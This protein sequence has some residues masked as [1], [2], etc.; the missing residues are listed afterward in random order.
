MKAASA[1]PLVGTEGPRTSPFHGTGAPPASDTL[2]ARLRPS[3]EHH[4]RVLAP[5][6]IEPDHRGEF[7][8]IEFDGCDRFQRGAAILCG[9]R[10]DRRADKAKPS[11]PRRAARQPRRRR[12]GARGRDVETGDPGMGDPRAQD[13]AFELPI[14]ADVRWCSAPA[15]HF[16]AC[17]QTARHKPRRRRDRF[18]LRRRSGRDVPPC[19]ARRFVAL[20]VPNGLRAGAGGRRGGAADES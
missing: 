3:C 12:D 2:P 9:D 17:R 16:V 20:A 1:C 13:D 14:V 4:R 7:F 18:L 15:R 19:R 11:G 8:A 5:R 6:R 10:G